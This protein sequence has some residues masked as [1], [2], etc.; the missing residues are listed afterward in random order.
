MNTVGIIFSNLHDKNIPEL[1]RNR[2]MGSIPFACRYRLV[3]FALSNMV[4]AGINDISIITHNN[5]R[6]LLDHIRSG[7]DWDLAR[8]S[9]G[10]Q[11]LPPYIGG[12][13]PALYNT[14]LEALK[15]ISHIIERMTCDHII[16][17]DCDSVCNI[18]LTEM[19]SEHSKSGAD[20]TIA[21]KS[22]TEKAGKPNKFV[23]VKS[24]ADKR[25][26]DIIDREQTITDG[27]ITDIM[28]NVWAIRREYLQI[29][30][31]ESIVHGTNSFLNDIIASGIPSHNFRVYHYSGVFTNIHSIT[32]YYN[33]SMELIKNPAT[34]EG[35][36]GIKNQPVLTRT[37]NSA[38]T[39]YGENCNVSGSLI[40]DGC[41]IEGTV[42]NSLLFRGVRVA[43]GAVVKNSIL[44]QDVSVATDASLNCVIADKNVVIHEGRI[45]SGH[46]TLPFCIE[47]G[48][49]I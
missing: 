21:T 34:R 6:S 41:V 3:D 1:T 13:N 23:I 22:I 37:H 40:A 42:I 43:K 18:N 48:R 5:Y 16:L 45:L 47:K 14:R 33:C 27:K 20:I 11:I 35:L 44:F 12:N 4:N 46:E 9:G 15:S 24:S 8:R 19:L 31:K 2:A 32:D 17:S 26:T 49:N 39:K 36:F 38:P 30:V 29:A 7:K 25:I 28:I 10:L